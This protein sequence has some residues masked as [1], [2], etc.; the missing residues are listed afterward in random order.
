MYIHRI[1]PLPEET[2]LPATAREAAVSSVAAG[3][4]FVRPMAAHVVVVIHVVRVL[5]RVL[6]GAH[7]VS[8]VQTLGLGELV[9]LGADNTGQEFLGGAVADVLAWGQSDLS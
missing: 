5:L 6:V 1:A 4:I 7:L 8:L 3:V 9:D 2:F